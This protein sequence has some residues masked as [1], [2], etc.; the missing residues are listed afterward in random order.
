MEHR[1]DDQSLPDQAPSGARL[2]PIPILV[3]LILGLLA[4]QVFYH[5]F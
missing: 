1:S 5:C 3:G 2:S 4:F